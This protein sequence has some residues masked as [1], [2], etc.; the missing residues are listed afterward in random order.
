MKSL[1]TICEIFR[2]ELCTKD[3]TPIHVHHLIHR[4]YAN[5]MCI[6]YTQDTL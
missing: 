4:L 6:H 2:L 3:T 5:V 1:P